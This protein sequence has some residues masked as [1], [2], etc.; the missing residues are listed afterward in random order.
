[1]EIRREYGDIIYV[2]KCVRRMEL[3]THFFL[4]SIF[5]RLPQIFFFGPKLFEFH[6]SSISTKDFHPPLEKSNY[7]T[8]I[9]LIF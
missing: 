5:L 2:S 1:M 8:L 7:F 3:Q 9:G 4:E 6:N